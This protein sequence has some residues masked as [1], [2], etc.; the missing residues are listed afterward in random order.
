MELILLERVKNL[1]ELGD[2][3]NVKSGYGRN[4]LLPKGKALPATE[5][6]REVYEAR[7]AELLKKAQIAVDEAKK[8]AAGFAGLVLTVKALTADEGRL[9]GSVGPN[10]VV[11]AALAR[12][13]ELD[14]SEV[15]MPS[16]PIRNTGTYPV[17][18]RLHGEVTAEISV[19]VVEE[20]S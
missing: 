12:S 2:K 3:V 7:K 13:L 17:T 14:R 10:E 1:G 20:K 18:L 9:Y 6:N 19:I 4:Y 8:R 5:K 16:G 15:D 11:R